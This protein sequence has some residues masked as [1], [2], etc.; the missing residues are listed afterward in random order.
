MD[1]K[2]KTALVTGAAGGMGL[3]IARALQ[4]QG[5]SVGRLDVK[6]APPGTDAASDLYFRGDLSDPAFV[7]ASVDTLFERTGRLDYL[8]NAAGVLWFGR[9]V[10]M[11]DIDLEV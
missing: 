7:Q 5:A 4:A 8:V 2:A 9:D 3:A 1:F 10:S 11:V 6:P